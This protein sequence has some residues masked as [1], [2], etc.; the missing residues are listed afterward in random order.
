MVR[1]MV[2]NGYELCCAPRWKHFIQGWSSL[3]T[4]EKPMEEGC[5]YEGEIE[6]SVQS[7]WEGT[8]SCGVSLRLGAVEVRPFSLVCRALHPGT[9]RWYV[10][11]VHGGLI[12]Q[13]PEL[14]GL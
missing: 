8:S 12:E 13:E 4:W 7:A 14:L 2:G 3:D 1:G 6:G 10:R 5:F 11:L 9:Q